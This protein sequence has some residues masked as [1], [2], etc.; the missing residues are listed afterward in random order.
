MAWTVHDNTLIVQKISIYKIIIIKTSM[1]QL[2]QQLMNVY[3]CLFT[4]CYNNQRLPYQHPLDIEAFSLGFPSVKSLLG[5]VF[6][7]SQKNL[8]RFKVLLL[9]LLLH[10]PV[11]QK[12]VQ[13][14]APS[15]AAYCL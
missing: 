7:I 11:S 4:Y 9:L 10:C 13:S 2:L 5:P 1:S 8:P 15:A 6:R 12:L 14:I 3:S